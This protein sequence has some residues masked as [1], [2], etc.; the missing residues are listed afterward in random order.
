MTG[1]ALRALGCSVLAI[2]AVAL[3]A[4]GGSETKA[5]APGS[6]GE[7]KPVRASRA[8]APCPVT[9]PRGKAL[10]SSE[11]FN[12]GNRFLAV[13]LWPR[14]R[15][16]AGRL[17][18]GSIYAEAKPDGSVEAKL[19]WWRAVEGPLTIG[20]ERLDASSPPLRA[21]VPVGYGPKGFQATRLTFPTQGCWKVVG[22][23]RRVSLSFVVL[24]RKR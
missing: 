8:V 11:G 2:A 17:P 12:Y 20:G 6:A 22:T 9:S 5:H 1:L 18:D 10:A 19:G 7:S 4:C 14:G 24:V 13:A 16:V 3:A 23:I 15:L 21:H